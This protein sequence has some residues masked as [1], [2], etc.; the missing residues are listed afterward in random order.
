MPD[1]THLHFI[2]P[3]FLWGFIPLILF[4]LLFIRQRSPSNSWQN[5]G[6]AHLIESLMI[7]IGKKTK[8]LAA[9][10]LFLLGSIMILALSGPS[11]RQQIQQSFSKQ[12]ATVIALDMSSAMSGSDI[13][14]SRLMRAKFKI[15]DLLSKLKDGQVGLVVFTRESFLVSPLTKDHSTL[16][17]LLSE[18]N[19]Q[20]MPIDGSNIQAPLKRS[21]SLIKQG[22]FDQGHIV[23]F[24]ANA[25]D[26]ADIAQAK[27]LAQ[28]NIHVSVIGMATKLGA[29]IYDA[30]HQ[31]LEK[32]SKLDE[33]SL[34]K[35][36]HD[37]A[38]LFLPFSQTNQDIK[39]LVSYINNLNTD[40]KTEKSEQT[41]W[42]DDGRY[43]I[44]LLLPFALLCFRRGFMETM[45]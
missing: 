13:K 39:K 8:A 24:T 33:K 31:S 41:L 29:P 6:D 19:P 35:L 26:N 21:A 4:L 1:I 7:N 10:I 18:L 12:Q 14:P 5:I 17:N 27:K 15:K 22:G 38:G 32:V 45:S 36:S 40:Y 11:F 34:N 9:I 43:L 44:F 2:R 16:L 25:A 28:E 30:Y 20:V 42:Q 23:L 37:G 3:Y